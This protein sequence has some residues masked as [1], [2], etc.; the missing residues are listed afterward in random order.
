MLGSEE[1]ESEPKKPTSA[2][3]HEILCIL[4]SY[5]EW[6]HVIVFQDYY[7]NEECYE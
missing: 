3:D 6:R 7:Y 1:L 4:A 2:S 5:C